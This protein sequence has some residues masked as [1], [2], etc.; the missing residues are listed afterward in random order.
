MTDPQ[1]HPAAA[2]FPMLDDDDLAALA[3]DIRAN[4][5]MHPIVLN[6]D[7]VLID[8]R[9]RL[10]ACRLA[11]V[12]PTFAT[13]DPPDLL[14]FIVSENVNRR[15]MGQG[16]KAMAVTQ[17]I[18]EQEKNR[19]H[20]GV[21]QRHL[22]SLVGVGE[23]AMERASIVHKY[24]PDLVNRVIAGESL[25]D[26]YVVAVNRKQQ[27]DQDARTLRQIRRDFPSLAEQVDRGELTIPE[28]EVVSQALHRKRQILLEVERINATVELRME[29]LD[30]ELDISP[31]RALALMVRQ[32]G[33]APAP[34]EPAA[35]PERADGVIE[36][37]VALMDRDEIELHQR[38]LDAL[39]VRD[40]L[41]G[42]VQGNDPVSLSDDLSI[43]DAADLCNTLTTILRWLAVAYEAA[44]A[45]ARG[46]RLEAVR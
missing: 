32:V 26:A 7:G 41:L 10:A 31:A 14:A 13:Y 29:R 11:G 30:R 5:L 23:Q 46:G 43:R 37:A 6:D 22:R 18:R 33:Q 39:R 8:G 1:I 34:P 16:A 45:V 3:A 12:E 44:D 28:A 40:R 21:S 9:N 25:D 19:G 24:A 27:G 20:H 4:G 36:S 42:M 38:R 35:P 2:V 15:H 17:A